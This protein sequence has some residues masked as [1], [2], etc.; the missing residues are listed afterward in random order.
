MKGLR[1]AERVAAA[2]ACEGHGEGRVTA[3][4]ADF[5]RGTLVLQAWTGV[6]LGG[7][8]WEW[9]AV[10][11]GLVGVRV[12]EPGLI[13]GIGMGR[14][15]VGALVGWRRHG[16]WFTF[17]G[18]VERRRADCE[19]EEEEQLKVCGTR[20]HAKICKQEEAQKEIVW[21][22]IWRWRWG[23][24]PGGKSRKVK[25][26]EGREGRKEEEEKTE[27]EKVMSRRKKE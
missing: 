20:W 24:G 19:R 6:L 8:G 17:L 27:W 4:H 14:V 16:W 22:V 1:M 26:K 23:E 5:G 9:S 25:E 11:M 3:V 18:W 2:V 12:F 21:E 13:V 7:N 15:H 10:D